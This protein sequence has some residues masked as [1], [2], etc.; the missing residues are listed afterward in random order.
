MTVK[1]HIDEKQIVSAIFALLD[2]DAELSGLLSVGVGSNK[3]R[4]ADQFESE[5]T[6]AVVLSVVSDVPDFAVSQKHGMVV[7]I[8]VSTRAARL[9]QTD[10]SDPQSHTIS[11]KRRIREILIGY[12]GQAHNV[13]RVDGCT[14]GIIREELDIPLRKDTGRDSEYWI[15]TTQFRINYVR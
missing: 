10:V 1:D 2:A 9:R 11:I 7:Q 4:F 13:L 8:D 5:T 12:R 3:I 14:A 15:A 6:P